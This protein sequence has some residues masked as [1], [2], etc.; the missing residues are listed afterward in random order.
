MSGLHY[1]QVRIF[2]EAATVMK[3]SRLWLLRN[4]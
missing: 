1:W 4:R 2:Q 3:Y